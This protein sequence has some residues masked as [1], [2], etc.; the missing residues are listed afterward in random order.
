M[1]EDRISA[2]EERV[3]RLEGGGQEPKPRGAWWDLSEQEREP[4]GAERAAERRVSRVDLEKVDGRE[5]GAAA[6]ALARVAPRPPYPVL[7]RTPSPQAAIRPVPPRLNASQAPKRDLEDF[8][9][10][11]VFAW[12]GGVAV[13]AGLAF[14]LTIAVSRGWIG[15]GARTVL[16]GVLSAGLLG[17]GVWLRERKR[18]TEASLAAAAVGIAGLFGTLVVAGPVYH[19]VPVPL[20]FA[21]AFATGTLATV[22][23]IHWRAQ[24]MG[25]LGLLG[26]LFAPTALGAV[27]GG[28]VVFLAIA[29]AATVGVVISQRWIALG[30]VAYLVTTIQWLAYVL[31]VA[32]SPAAT[33]IA[34]GVLS[35]VYAVALEFNRR[36]AQ[37]VEIGPQPRLFTNPVAV[38]VLA[39]NAT[40]LAATGWTALD[41]ELWLAGLA[42]AQ[43][44]LGLSLIHVK[45]VS[46]E[47]ALIALAVGIVLANIA[48][49]SIATGLP[50]VLGWALSAIPFAAVLGA[51]SDRPN[52][53]TKLVDTVLGR[54]DDESAARA[55]RILALAGLAGQIALTGFQ[56][57]AFDAPVSQLNGPLAS[58][59]AL[60]AAGA[61][62][63]VTWACARLAGGRYRMWLDTL[64][65]TA[66]AHFT[67][68]ALEG[69]ALAAT[70]AAE[71]LA[72]GALARRHD[73]LYAAWAA[74]AFAAISLLVT[75]CTLATPD[76]LFVGL[77]APLAAAGGLAAG[78]AALF[79]ISR[80]PLGVEH[81][82]RVLETAA[83]VTLLYLASVEVVTFAGPTHTGQ[84][85]LSVLWAL[86]GVGALIRGLLIDDRQLRQGALILL[87][88]SIAKV[89]L[90]DLA[91]LDSLYRVGS[92]V[93][94]GL[95][96]LCAAFAWQQVRPNGAEAS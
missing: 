53:L 17:V 70:L 91:S 35:V 19:L 18:Q 86:A 74:A 54:P 82:R 49:G 45:R 46:R 89:F 60:A 42:V 56:G 2:L 66:V 76:M 58:S 69:A 75:L 8:V 5:V 41:G 12:L 50:L 40:I 59:A 61:I 13:L 21:G 92:L 81:S 14:L 25:W 84:T 24:V 85:L 20:A 65:L 90:Y 71:A 7:G 16:A 11:S 48:F 39:L 62:A 32:S 26:A 63:V 78:A 22:L 34:F 4:R 73:D 33:L 3:A 94:L 27:N 38:G 68:L 80:V 1:V 55:D 36:G 64:A 72:L 77:G 28:G 37:P 96:L 10:G 83:A 88:V 9:A 93:G 44:A 47:F 29:F 95:L 6:E 30:L 31:G 43:L 79:A 15:E 23:A 52:G 51:R 57:L 67:G 87:G